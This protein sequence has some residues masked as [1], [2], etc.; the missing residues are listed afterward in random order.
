MGAG[1][2]PRTFPPTI[3]PC[4]SPWISHPHPINCIGCL[5]LKILP[6]FVV[7]LLSL[8]ANIAL[9]NK[10]KHIFLYF[11]LISFFLIFQIFRWL[12]GDFTVETFQVSGNFPGNFR[13]LPRI[14]QPCD[15]SLAL[16]L[17][18]CLLKSLALTQGLESSPWPWPWSSSPWPWPWSSSPWPWPWNPS[19]WP[20]PWTPSPC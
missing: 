4:H 11:F 13:K 2:S 8:L 20:W 9:N 15:V 10:S 1:H 16:V 19:P 18:P 12:S 14:F 3:S 5:K 6:N 7:N 17:G